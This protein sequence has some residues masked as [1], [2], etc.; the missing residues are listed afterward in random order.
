MMVSTRPMIH[1]VIYISADL[2]ISPRVL[3][4]EWAPHREILRENKR[5]AP[6]GAMQATP[7]RGISCP[8]D[9]RLRPG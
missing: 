3:T 9:A 7:K 8:I 4:G 2:F 1:I 6:R 5:F